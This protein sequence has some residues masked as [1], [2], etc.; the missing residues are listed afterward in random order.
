MEEQHSEFKNILTYHEHILEQ[1]NIRGW[2]GSVVMSF[3][4]DDLS[5]IDLSGK[6]FE[7]TNLFNLDFKRSLLKDCQFDGAYIENTSFNSSDLSG[8][9]F[10]SSVIYSSDMSKAKLN[11]CRFDSVTDMRSIN[12]SESDLTG[13]QF[14]K[15]NLYEC[16]LRYVKLV[17]SV[18]DRCYFNSPV[19][20]L[21][22]IDMSGSKFENCY[23]NFKGSIEKK[24]K[25]RGITISDSFIKPSNVSNLFEGVDMEGS[26]FKIIREWGAA[27]TNTNMKNA[28]FDKVSAISF[29][30]SYSITSRT[31]ELVNGL[32]LTGSNIFEYIDDI[33][34]ES[35]R[36][37]RIYALLNKCEGVPRS[38]KA[39]AFGSV[40]FGN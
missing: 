14:S 12:F 16:N 37:E 25:A 10:L 6:N 31:R 36:K 35:S 29:F 2:N 11:D 8:S 23:L 3:D 17:D 22:G 28:T 40:A 15:C 9:T 18:F 32:D 33:I 24:I 20:E 21:S 27:L 5:N 4:R 39:S 38:L 13:S 34:K 30:A 7:N 26:K 19:E 1:V